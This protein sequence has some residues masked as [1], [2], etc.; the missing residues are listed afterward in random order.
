M[1]LTIEI[2]DRER[3]EILREALQSLGFEIVARRLSV[4]D[5]LLPGGTVVERKTIDDFCLSVIDGRLFTQARSLSIKTERPLILI[6]GPGF[7]NR[8]VQISIEAVK[9]ALITLAQTFRVPVLRSRDEQDSAWHIKQLVL[10]QELM[11]THPGPVSKSRGRITSRRKEQ[12]LRAF[13]GIGPSMAKKLLDGFGSIANIA[14]ASPDELRKIQG[15]GPK[16][17]RK[18]INIL[19]E[20]QAEYKTARESR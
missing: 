15:L 10:Q 20:K 6:E 12:I 11:G 2:D 7:N 16:T 18:I 8:S 9:G 4:G 14:S 5:Y 13:P 17:A 19:R 1:S 3:A